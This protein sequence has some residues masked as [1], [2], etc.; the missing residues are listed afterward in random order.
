MG[1]REELDEM[2]IEDGGSKTGTAVHKPHLLRIH[3]QKKAT[4]HRIFHQRLAFVLIERSY[5]ANMYMAC[6]YAVN[7]P[8]HV[9]IA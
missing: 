7:T 9:A 3:V 8:S 2:A 4:V 6:C 5:R 1:Y